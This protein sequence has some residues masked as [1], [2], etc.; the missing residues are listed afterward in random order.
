MTDQPTAAVAAAIR[1][2]LPASY[3]PDEV[4]AVAD[5]TLIA[6][7]R[8]CAAELRAFADAVLRWYDDGTASPTILGSIVA[9]ALSTADSWETR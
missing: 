1:P 2:Y 9:A 5:V 7:R 8:Q 6:A 3:R 4:A